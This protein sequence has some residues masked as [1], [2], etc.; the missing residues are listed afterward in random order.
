MTCGRPP[1]PRGPRAAVTK[2]RHG[3]ATRYT[4]S[5]TALIRCAGAS[6][7]DNPVKLV[8]LTVR[9]NGG[10]R[11]CGDVHAEWVLGSVR[12]NAPLQ[13]VSDLDKRVLCW[14]A[15]PGLVTS[16]EHRIPCCR[17][18]RSV[19][20][21]RTEFLGARLGNATAY[22]GASVFPATLA[23]RSTPVAVMTNITL[24]PGE[25]TESLSSWVS[26]RISHKSR[27]SAP[28]PVNPSRCWPRCNNNGIPLEYD[29]VA[30]PDAA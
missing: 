29:Q 23:P 24:A 6:S 20:A 21:D 12:E 11:G 10:G 4:T 8:C 3:Q 18:P 13:V 22:S 9:N 27:P 5:V 26:V 14:R 28:T 7:H 2:S 19:T 30:T 25:T 15:T 17:P 1:L 16:P